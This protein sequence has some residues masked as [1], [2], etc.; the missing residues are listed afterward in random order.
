MGMALPMLLSGL[1]SLGKAFGLNTTIMQAL[2]TSHKAK[3]ALDNAD[4]AATK[5]RNVEA[6]KDQVA[7][8][9]LNKLREEGVLTSSLSVKVLNEET[10]AKLINKVATDADKAAIKQATI[11]Q[12]A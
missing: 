12:N 5:A 7:Q 1:N 4:I 3:L 2:N 10:K 11:A 9:A 6:I 8:R